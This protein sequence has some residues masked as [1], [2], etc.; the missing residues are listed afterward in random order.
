MHSDHAH[1]DIVN[2][3]GINDPTREADSVKNV[4]SGT[5]ELKKCGNMMGVNG[6]LETSE[7][8]ESIVKGTNELENNENVPTLTNIP[9]PINHNNA[10]VLTS[11]PKPA[12]NHHKHHP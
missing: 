5:N 1:Q 10:S 11:G 3:K 6:P 12:V 7:Y 2:V 8:T 4:V 9:T